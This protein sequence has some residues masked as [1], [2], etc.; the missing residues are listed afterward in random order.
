MRRVMLV[1]TAVL[2]SAV[3]LASCG[4]ASEDAGTPRRR[5]RH[6]RPRTGLARL[7]GP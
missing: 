5:Y 3:I 1:W 2:L 4:G 6:P 7:P